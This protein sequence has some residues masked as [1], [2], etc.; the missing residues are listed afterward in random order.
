MEFKIE[1]KGLDN[2]KNYNKENIDIAYKFAASAYKEFKGL[3]KSIVLFGSTARGKDS[4]DIDILIIIDD[5]SVTLTKEMIETYRIINQRIVADVSVKLHITSLKLKTFWEYVRA[6]DPVAINILRD[7]VALLDTGI[8]DPL[9]ILLKQGRIRPSKESV[10]SYYNRAPK[11]LFNAK[12]HILQGVVDLYWAV[13]DSAHAAL[14]N[15]NI[16]PP[17]PEL[18]SEILDQE[19][20]KNGLL[21]KDYAITMKKFYVLQKK[22][23]HRD[24]KD[25]SGREFDK[26]HKEAECFVKRMAKFL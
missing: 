23:L 25:I 14:M 18:V 8:F 22:I 10:Y 2:I 16:V 24:I 21:E 20:V 11:T 5:V 15:S 3:V 26:Y 1:K 12:W 17:S 9:Q 7:G 13:I 19:F 6:G 4:N